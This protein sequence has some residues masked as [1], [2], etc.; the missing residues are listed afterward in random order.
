MASFQA[1]QPSSAH[2]IRAGYLDTPSKATASPS[3]SSSG[4]AWPW[5]CISSRNAP[6]IPMASRTVLP[7]TM[8]ASTDALAWLIE[9]PSAS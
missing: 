9:Q 2:L 7:I 4:S 5:D 1:I 3:R 8:S 6:L